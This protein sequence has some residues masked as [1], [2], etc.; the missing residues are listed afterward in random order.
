MLS[1]VARCL[2]KTRGFQVDLGDVEATLLGHPAI[3]EVGVVAQPHPEY[4]NLLYA[5]VVPQAGQALE[6][7]PLG[8]M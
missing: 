3:A 8:M 7:A 5:F 1:A 4:T 2:I 6:V